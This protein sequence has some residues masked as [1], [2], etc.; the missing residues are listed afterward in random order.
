LKDIGLGASLY[1]L[2]IKAFIRFFFILNLMSIPII[3][4]YMSGNEK[5]LAQSSGIGFLFGMLNLGNLGESGPKCK[6]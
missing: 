5:D 6:M 1:L 2:T 4:I 3:C